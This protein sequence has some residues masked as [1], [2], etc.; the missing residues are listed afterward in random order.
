MTLSGRGPSLAVEGTTT[1]RVFETYI[2]KVLVPTLHKGRIVV[3]DNLSAHGPKRIREL[4][5]RAE[6]VNCSTCRLTP[7]TTTP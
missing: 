1:A 4:C 2:E 5:L 7:P 3:M 6:G